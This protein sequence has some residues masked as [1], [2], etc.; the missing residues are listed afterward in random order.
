M[1]LGRIVPAPAVRSIVGVGKMDQ[2]TDRRSYFDRQPVDVAR[3]YLA[4]WSG[5]M[6]PRSPERDASVSQAEH[7]REFGE[8]LGSNGA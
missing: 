1:S 2:A 4:L 5:G 7:I 6:Q 8:P 3:L